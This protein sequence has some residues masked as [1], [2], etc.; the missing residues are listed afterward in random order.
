MIE[1]ESL[2]S[3]RTFIKSAIVGAA[4]TLMTDIDKHAAHAYTGAQ[5]KGQGS[6]VS[7]LGLSE[8]SQL[9][10]SKKVSPVELT[11]E[12]LSRIERLNPKLNAFI[13]VTADSALAEARQAEAEI[14]RDRWRGP[15]HGIPIALKDLIDTAGVRTTAASGLFKDRVPTQD[16]EIV[17]RLKAAGA[18]FLGKLNLHEFAYGGSSAIS[19]FAP[20]RNPWDSGHSPGGS[21]GGSAAAVAAQLCYAAIGSDTGGSV[22]QPAGYCGIVGLKPTYGRVSTSGVIP[23]SWSQDHLGPMTRTATDAALMLQV[24]A[25]YDPQDTAS[26]DTPVADYA[27][28]I[29]APTFP[30][31]LGILRAYFYDA[32]NPEIQA[33]MDAAL[34][35]LKTLTRTQRDI[36]PLAT[37]STY[38]SVMDPYVTI[39]KAE[40]Y[41][42]H[43]EYVSKSPE[44]Y[45]AQ[46]LKRIQ[47]GAD[48][49]TSAYIQSR[50]QLEQIRRSV[51]RV[52]DDVDAL[53]TPTAPVPPFAIADLEADPNTLREK[54]L[55]MLRN[56]RPFNMLGL[57][58]V[59]IPCG[60]TSADLPIGMQLTGPPGGEAMVLRL[61]YAYEQAT[62]WHKRKPNLD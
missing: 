48:V 10:R 28:T 8:A 51:S 15:L 18:V 30:L 35:V 33:A 9:V 38:S 26:T 50:R 40:A 22:R 45:Q 47:A 52:F 55:L 27:A 24:I 21:S 4:G 3:R 2:R 25:G 43:K 32:L 37:D 1:E 44:L 59:S 19:Y 7:Q 16:A 23:L 61:A 36:A 20:V 58:T 56:T 54:E 6:N 17:R 42:Y 13:T 14:Q 60:F 39:L 46:T 5:Q 34:S 12:C 49:T 53:V 62:E 57:P 11:R 41:A 29:A 31:R